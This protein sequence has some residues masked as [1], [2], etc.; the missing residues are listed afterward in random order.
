M[1][2]TL[3]TPL[4]EGTHKDT[5]VVPVDAARGEAFHIPVGAAESPAEFNQVIDQMDAYARYPVEELNLGLAKD[6]R[7]LV[8]QQFG[9]V[10]R[11]GFDLATSYWGRNLTLLNK[12][13]Y[14]QRNSIW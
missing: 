11:G 9:K 12:L 14:E 5:L 8:Q 3:Q 4:E 7:A 1:A 10:E 2:D 13:I 6:F